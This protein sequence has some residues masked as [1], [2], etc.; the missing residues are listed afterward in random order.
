MHGQTDWYLPAKA[1]LNVIY[2]N[3]M[4]IGGFDLSGGSPSGYYWSSTEDYLATTWF[5]ILINGSTSIAAKYFG[6]SVRCAR[7]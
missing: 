5:Q 6:F 7:K 1:E 4:A 2:A 3:R